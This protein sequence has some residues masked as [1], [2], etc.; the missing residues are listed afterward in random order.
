[1]AILIDTSVLIAWERRDLFPAE[2]IEVLP[3]EPTGIS[4]ITASELLLGVHRANTEERRLKRFA[5]VE[6]VFSRFPIL[7]FDLLTARAHAS[8]SGQI[9]AAG[10]PIGA[11]DLIIA[12]TAIANGYDIL[13]DNPRDFARVPGLIV[14]RPD[15]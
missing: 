5:S 14:R 10:R 6:A 13:T 15:W 4:S 11:H 3:N 1:M 9:A 2:L 8:L 7:A 12:A